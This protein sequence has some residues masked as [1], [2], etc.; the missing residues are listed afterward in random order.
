[1]I[2][3][4]DNFEQVTAAATG[5][6]ELIQHCH[7]LKVV[8][9]SRETLRVRAEHVFPV[10]PLAMPDPNSSVGEIASAEAVQLFAERARAVR[11]D[12]ALDASNAEIVAL[13]CLRLDGI[14]LAIELAAAR[15]K[16]FSPRDLLERLQGRLDVL[17]AGGRDLPDRQRTLWGAIGWSYEL[18]DEAERRVFEMM[19]VFSSS[20]L[21]AIETVAGE[22]LDSVDIYDT[23]ASLVD[24]SLVRSEDSDGSRRFSML[25]MVKEFAAERLSRDSANEEAVRSAHAVFF[26]D[27]AVGLGERLTGP[28][29]DK[30]L[31]ELPHDIGN[32]RSAWRYWVARGD[33]E[34]LFALL[35]GLWALH[36]AQGW[37][38]AAISAPVWLVPSLPSGDT[39]SKWRRHS[40]RCS[41]CQGPRAAQPSS[42]R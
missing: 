41:R 13:I 40:K 7:G 33:L 34:E 30:V 11:P 28:E 42:S 17:G 12:F 20:R 2:L 27:Y 6:V 5:V 36:D 35:E 32:L 18:L 14:P 15:M 3:L 37:Y 24:K 39:T 31:A 26:R 25:Q 10:P 23:L 19:S 22:V 21:E 16:V 38:H 29:R 1:M 4:L 8:V 9:T